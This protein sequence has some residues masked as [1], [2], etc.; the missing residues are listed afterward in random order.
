[1]NKKRAALG[2]A[3]VFVLIAAVFALWRGREI[4]SLLGPEQSSVLIGG[5][6]YRK[7]EDADAG[8]IERGRLL[9]TV[10]STD[11]SAA[12]RVYA[13]KGSDRLIL[14]VSEDGEEILYER[15]ETL[16]P[17]PEKNDEDSERSTP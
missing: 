13:V 1:M 8:E 2:A 17:A 3:A 4:G 5:E 15:I 11:R 6:L 7:A 14:A 16:P 10:V 9:G 12:K